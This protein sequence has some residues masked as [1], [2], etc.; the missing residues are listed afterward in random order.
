MFGVGA[1]GVQAFAA[2]QFFEPMTSQE[3][4][5]NVIAYKAVIGTCAKGW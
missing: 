1:K 2:V 5:P 4:T 3:L